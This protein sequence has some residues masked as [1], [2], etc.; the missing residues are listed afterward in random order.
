MREPETMKTA[1]RRL[2]RDT[3][4]QNIAEYGIALAVVGVVAATAALRIGVNVNTLFTRALQTL[5]ITLIRS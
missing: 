4:G 1:L 3:S 2:V 5:V